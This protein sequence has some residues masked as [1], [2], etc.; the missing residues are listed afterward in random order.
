MLDAMKQ[1]D[2]KQYEK[3]FQPEVEGETEEEKKARSKASK[4]QFKEMEKMTIALYGG[5]GDGSKPWERQ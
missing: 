2:M 1:F 4:K 5:Q 3:H